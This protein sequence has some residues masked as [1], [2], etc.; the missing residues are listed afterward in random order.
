MRDTNKILW[1]QPTQAHALFE[2]DEPQMFTHNALEFFEEIK[3]TKA[4]QRT[5]YVMDLHRVSF[6]WLSNSLPSWW[7]EAVSCGFQRYKP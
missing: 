4:R 5:T 6:S 1:K 7:S 3:G 2:R